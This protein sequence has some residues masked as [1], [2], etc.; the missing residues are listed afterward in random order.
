MVLRKSQRNIAT[1]FS[2]AIIMVYVV[3]CVA[4]HG[5]PTSRIWEGYTLFFADKHISEETALSFLSSE[6]CHEVISLGSQKVPYVSHFGPVL[7]QVFDDYLSARLGYFSDRSGDYALYYIPAGNEAQAIKAAEKLSKQTSLVAGTDGKRTYPFASPLVAVLVFVAL[8]V[9]SH[10]KAAFFCPA[11]LSLPLCFSQPFHSVVAA[12]VLFMLALYLTQRIW[13]RRRALAVAR[14]NLYVLVLLCVSLLVFLL[15]G[16]KAA[17]LGVLSFMAAISSL[18]LLHLMEHFLDK[19]RTFRIKKIFSATQ[20]PLVH[21]KNS[22]VVLLCSSPVLLILLLFAFS[23]KITGFSSIAAR[24]YFP[25]PSGKSDERGELPCLD[26]FYEWIWNVKAFPYRSLN[27]DGYFRKPAQGEELRVTR[28]EQ[29]NGLLRENSSVLMKFD[30]SFKNTT[31]K[32]IEHLEYPAI[33]KFMEKQGEGEQVVWGTGVR[34][35]E[36]HGP[37]SLVLILLCLLSPVALS[38]AFA[39]KSAFRRPVRFDLKNWGC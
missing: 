38:L 4:L 32:E 16:A 13:G 25:V 7:P 1:Y 33:E 14:K 23:S 39:I 36:E 19:R 11:V 18:Y 15:S 17:L 27:S 21:K 9:L 26:D 10:N 20:L 2:L 37:L 3:L 30:G 8:L 34:A 24:L 28:Y 31:D 35:K 29:K 5:E 12:A 22:S 6:G